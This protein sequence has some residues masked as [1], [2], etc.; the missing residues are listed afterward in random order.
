MNRKRNI[1]IIISIL[2]ISLIV[3]ILAEST[4]SDD[5]YEETN[6]NK[7][8]IE[9]FSPIAMMLETS[10][11]SGKYEASTANGWPETGYKFN[12]TLSK[13][14][15]GGKLSW[16]STTKKV[17][18]ISDSQDKC[19]AYFDVYVPP[20]FD[21]TC[22]E[23]TLACHVAKLYTGTQ[24]E[25]GIYYHDSSLTDGAGDNSYRY[26][27]ENP[28][29]YVC[30]GQCSS[31]NLFRII[32]VFDGKLKII[33]NDYATDVLGTEGTY[34]GTYENLGVDD[35]GTSKSSLDF[36]VIA[37]YAWNSA[38]INGWNNES[39]LPVFFTT[40]LNTYFL[41]NVIGYRD[42]I[43]NNIWQVGGIGGTNFVSAQQV[44]EVEI[45]NSNVTYEAQI[46]LMY[47]S[48]Y[49]FAAT[50]SSWASI[51]S[52]Y[53]GKAIIS[54]NWMYMGLRE[55]AMTPDN[56]TKTNAIFINQNGSIETG[57]VTAYF[58]VRPVMYLKSNVK[59][60]S[61]EGTNTSPYLIEY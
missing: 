27:G 61:G 30:I 14:V 54:D 15:N 4:H 23:T 50:P 42:I 40:N 52:D 45:T 44:Y 25:N 60:L 43:E 21:E 32:G 5:I 24:G 46:G 10:A 49:A 12:S 19:Y 59:A 36:S 7:K 2:I 18:M 39:L 29:N 33:F 35:S 51:L 55:W 57:D 9:K 1:I 28:N 47:I 41:N 8:T 26:A 17:I 34:Y 20:R 13:C 58:A 22:D 3:I 53:E 16:D 37:T 38:S 6:T 56:I 11:G 31:D 48:D